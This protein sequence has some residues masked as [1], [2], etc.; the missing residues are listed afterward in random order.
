MLR[1]LLASNAVA[2]CRINEGHRCHLDVLRLLNI[3]PGI[4]QTRQLQYIHADNEELRLHRASEEYK[5][6]KA[7]QRYAASQA[8]AHSEAARDERRQPS[9]PGG[10]GEAAAAE[11]GGPRRA[12][13]PRTTPCTYAAEGCKKMYT[14]QT[15]AWCRH[16]ESCAHCPT[17]GAHA[18]AAAPT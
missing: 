4:F 16:V 8:V 1:G 15:K 13:K 7:E 6:G 12:S 10:G 3:E 11:G 17:E 14:G 2:S 5:T 18:A 9:Y